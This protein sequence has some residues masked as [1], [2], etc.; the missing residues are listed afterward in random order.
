MRSSFFFALL[1]L[2]S[3][4]VAFA[5]DPPKLTG[6][7][8]DQVGLIPPADK[9]YL[10]NQIRSLNREQGIQ[11]QILI[12]AS[13][14]NEP[15]EQAS[16]DTVEKWQL[17]TAEEDKGILIFVAP[18]EKKMRI[19]VGQGLEGV[20]PDILAFQIIQKK[21][22]PEFKTGEFGKGLIAA[23]GAIAALTSPES[24]QAQVTRQSLQQKK[25]HSQNFVKLIIFIVAFVLFSLLS[26]KRQRRRHPAH[27][28]LTGS[29]LGGGLGRGGGGGWSGGGGG[30]SGG[31][32]SGGW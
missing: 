6:P 32:A 15:I 21:I 22:L 9:G 16:I 25:S 8:V 30:F 2:Y 31:G 14:Q 17:G 7:V 23:V 27:A 5:F 18:N 28:F 19:E 10:E 4:F 20:I 24:R 13:L 12:V 11:A 1:F 3:P 26:A 29:I